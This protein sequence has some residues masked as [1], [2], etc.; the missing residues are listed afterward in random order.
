MRSGRAS[1]GAPWDT[2]QAV[3]QEEETEMLKA[4]AEWL[5]QQLAAVQERIDALEQE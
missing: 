3:S 1:W 5:Q 2:Q 4:Q